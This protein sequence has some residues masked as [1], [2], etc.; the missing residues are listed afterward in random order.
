MGVRC[1]CD[2]LR[3]TETIRVGR[4]LLVLLILGLAVYLLTPQLTS[5]EQSLG[6]IR[7]LVYWIVLLAVL[8]QVISY[9]GS[10][11]TLEAI[12]ELADDHLSLLRCTVIAMASASIGLIAGGILGISTSTYHW[13]H[14]QDE[15]SEGALLAGILPSLFNNLALVLL[16]I[17]GL[18]YLLFTHEL[19]I[20]QAIGFGVVLLVL[21]LIVVSLVI[22]LRRRAQATSLALWITLQWA[23][24]RKKPID[25][26]GTEAE[27][28]NI[29][30]ALDDVIFAG[31]WQG[32]SI[33]ALLNVGFD[34]LSLYFLFLA[35]RYAVSPG[36]LLA[37]YGLP[38]LLGKLAF[39]VPG[40]VGVIE[41]GMAT[42]YTS[43]GVP[44]AITVVVVLGYRLISFWLPT[45]LGFPLIAVLQ[46]K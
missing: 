5:L 18:I 42:L 32:P 1:E 36:V 34:I 11:Y 41:G 4:S 43:L 37:G 23:G 14:Q 33:G 22:A 8:A 19:S 25:K 39:I 21:G 28:R 45:L 12:L 13:I 10:G 35:A 9:L 2:L 3:M 24:L 7:S 46:R 27:I 30:A 40:G 44:P 6:V 15:E 31:G 29:F 16:A 20:A 38:L 17:F 26:K